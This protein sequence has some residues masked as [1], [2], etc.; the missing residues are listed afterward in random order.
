MGG[1]VVAVHKCK[2][3]T[4]NIPGGLLSKVL[5]ELKLWQVPHTKRAS[6]FLSCKATDFTWTFESNRCALTQAWYRAKVNCG[7]ASKCYDSKYACLFFKKK[8]YQ[9]RH[10][11]ARA[12]WW[13]GQRNTTDTLNHGVLVFQISWIAML[14]PHGLKESAGTENAAPEDG[15]WSGKST[16][17]LKL[18]DFDRPMDY[19]WQ[20][21]GQM[22]G[23]LATEKQWNLIWTSS[24]VT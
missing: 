7:K 15:G 23:Q 9:V 16:C 2:I 6:V 13:H 4:M 1:I 12:L 22:W 18:Y 10:H 19:P 20:R 8:P 17:N 11:G 24:K 5:C 21:R 14:E 3:S